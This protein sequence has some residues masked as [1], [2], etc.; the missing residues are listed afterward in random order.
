MNT[1]PVNM[2]ITKK[3]F[4]YEEAMVNSGLMNDHMANRYK[5]TVRIPSPAGLTCY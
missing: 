1:V 3:G 4:V 2:D 5:F